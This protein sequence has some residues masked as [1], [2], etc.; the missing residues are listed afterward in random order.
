MTEEEADTDPCAAPLPV[1]P[2]LVEMV[3]SLLR[4]VKRR[5]SAIAVTLSA[6]YT[7][8]PD[9]ERLGDALYECTET[10]GVVHHGTAE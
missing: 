4:T 9:S 10:M 5:R 3:A 6:L 1:R 8:E 7:T 2:P